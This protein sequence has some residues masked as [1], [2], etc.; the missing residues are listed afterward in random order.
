MRLADL[1]ARTVEVGPSRTEIDGLVSRKK[2]GEELDSGPRIPA[3][4]EFLESEL[5]RLEAAQLVDDADRPDSSLYDAFMR[6][7]VRG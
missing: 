7:V 2:A 1:V 4:S 6:E 5:E 3:I